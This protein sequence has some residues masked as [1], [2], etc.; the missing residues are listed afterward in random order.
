MLMCY[1]VD[2][3]GSVEGYLMDEDEKTIWKIIKSINGVKV[4]NNSG[5]EDID[6]NGSVYDNEGNATGLYFDNGRIVVLW[7]YFEGTHGT[8][9]L[10]DDDE[11]FIWEIIKSIVR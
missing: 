3:N 10:L 9:E 7:T 4:D 1:R 8:S 6:L 5:Y 2:G 11:D